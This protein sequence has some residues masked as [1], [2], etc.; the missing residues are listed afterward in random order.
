MKKKYIWEKLNSAFS[1]K[2]PKIREEILYLL[3]ETLRRH[4]AHHLPVS[5]LLTHVVKLLGDQN[6]MVRDKSLETILEM[7]K[8]CGEK[9]RNEIK[10]KQ[11]PE[12]K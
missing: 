12:A 5:K 1:H 6:Q 3:D 8:Y 9:L 11:I 4:Y 10:K 7:Y 2:L